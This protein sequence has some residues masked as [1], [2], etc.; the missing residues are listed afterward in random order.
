VIL[1]SSSPNYVYKW[2]IVGFRA[3]WVSVSQLPLI[4]CLSCK[5][6]VI[7]LITGI[8]YERLNWLHR[9]TARTI[10]LTVIVHWS[11]FVTEWSLANFVQLELQLMPMVKYGFAAWGVIG[12]MVLSSFGFLRS[13]IYEVWAVQHIL[14]AGV[15]LWLVHV[16]VPSYA[17]YNVWMA[18][19]FVAFDRTARLILVLARN[20]HILKGWRFIGNLWGF[21]A[22]ITRLSDHH[23]RVVIDNVDF[24][25]K[26]G[27]HIY[28][29][30]PRVGLLEN[31]PFTI[32]SVSQPSD[33]GSRTS[34]ELH[35]KVKSGFT[36]RLHRFLPREGS[37]L[38]FRVFVSGPW[39]TT[40]SL[41]GFD[42][43]VFMATGAGISFTAPMLS[44]AVNKEIRPRRI[45][46]VWV[47]RHAYQIDW[48]REH[49]IQTFRNAQ[50]RDIDITIQIFVTTEILGSILRPHSLGSTSRPQSWRSDYSEH[51][52]IIT[53]EHA[54]QQPISF[55]P[56]IL[57]A[58]NN[59][60]I[61]LMSIDEKQNSLAA[62]EIH[63][64]RPVLD[65]VLRPVIEDALGETGIFA[66]GNATFTADLR[67]YTART[68]DERAVHKGTGAHGLF[69]FTETYG[70]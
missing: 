19:G 8:S 47:V 57:N 33:C 37:N 70:W 12:L 40:P 62:F 16:H 18:I 58:S 66:C 7:S 67:N 38:T 36:R 20:V 6:N 23:L 55:P 30:V 45:S 53:K 61:D 31:H 54:Q 63:H 50:S 46:F 60:V 64:G 52:A 25:W 5:I 44:S 48:F 51:M 29:C 59:P 2:E 35:I 69:L 26:A 32:S 15:L 10:F 49:L 65:H 68:S 4:Y 24:S 14:M 3:A 27:Q 43:L 11:F 28:I 22:R 1:S 21:T 41:D 13:Q 39:G 34:L 9:W 42:T 17:A 56:D